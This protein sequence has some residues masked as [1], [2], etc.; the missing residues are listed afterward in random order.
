MLLSRVNSVQSFPFMFFGMSGPG[1]SN[2]VDTAAPSVHHCEESQAPV[3]SLGKKCQV[4][5]WSSQRV[6]A[7][8]SLPSQCVV[9]ETQG[10]GSFHTWE[11]RGILG[12]LSPASPAAPF[13]S[14]SPLWQS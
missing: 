5:G 8:S 2:G 3:F 1:N 10:F 4:S 14:S 6:L 12:S 7:L 9:G 13:S 11:E